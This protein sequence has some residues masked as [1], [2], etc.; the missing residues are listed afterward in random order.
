M[1]SNYGCSGISPVHGYPPIVIVQTGPH[2]S[3]WFRRFQNIRRLPNF[4]RV[5]NTFTI[6]GSLGSLEPRG[7][8]GDIEDRLLSEDYRNL[9][10]ILCCHG[11]R[12]C[13]DVEGVLCY[14]PCLDFLGV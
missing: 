5:Y 7:L 6:E 14:K 9:H 3:S 11:F 10:T 4:P 8:Y 2:D 1:I 13:L 12:L